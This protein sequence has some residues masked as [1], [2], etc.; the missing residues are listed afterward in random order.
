MKQYAKLTDRSLAVLG[1]MIIP[2]AD[3]GFSERGG[4]GLSQVW[5]KRP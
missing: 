5:T 4:G 2:E 3:T 1:E